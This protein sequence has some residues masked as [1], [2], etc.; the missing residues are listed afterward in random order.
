MLPEISEK[1]KRTMKALKGLNYDA[2]GVSAREFYD[3]LTGEI[4]SEDKTTLRDVLDSEYLMVHE[5]VEISELKKMGRRI[6][7]RVVVDSPRTVIYEAHLS[8][9]EFEMD[10]AL[11]RRDLAWLKERIGHH[12]GVLFDDPNLPEAMRPRARAIYEK[13]R[14]YEDSH[15]NP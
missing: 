14:K 8:A 12:R 11:M 2:E 9:M 1:I 13:F 5:L 4:F 10:Y 7:R 6:D 15:P 3:F